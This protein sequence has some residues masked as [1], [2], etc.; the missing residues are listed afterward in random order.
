MLP[1]E[2]SKKLHSIVKSSLKNIITDRV[3][4]KGRLV[5]NVMVNKSC[6]TFRISDLFYLENLLDIQS[7]VKS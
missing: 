7:P 5:V 2:N 4:S 3:R 1:V 6:D